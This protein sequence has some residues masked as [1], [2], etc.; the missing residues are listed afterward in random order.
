[1]GLHDIYSQLLHG[2]NEAGS[3]Q[4]GKIGKNYLLYEDLKKKYMIDFKITQEHVDLIKSILPDSYRPNPDRI[5]EQKRVCNELHEV[6]FQT[7]YE[8]EFSDIKRVL[9]ITNLDRGKQAFLIYTSM[10]GTEANKTK[11]NEIAKKMHDNRKAEL[12]ALKNPKNTEA[13]DAAREDLDDSMNEL[14]QFIKD[15]VV[16]EIRRAA[17]EAPNIEK[18]MSDST[19]PGK[20]FSNYRNI[21]THLVIMN[22]SEKFLALYKD[23]FSKEEYAS[24]CKSFGRVYGKGMDFLTVTGQM[25]NP[26]LAENFDMEEMKLLRSEELSSIEDSLE[27]WEEYALAEEDKEKEKNLSPEEK[28]K[29]KEA[30][31]TDKFKKEGEQSII[32]TM[33]NYGTFVDAEWRMDINN[34][35]GKESG[36]IV[37]QTLDGEEKLLSDEVIAELYE[38]GLP[39][40]AY[41][42]SADKPEGVICMPT[43]GH[44]L[45]VGKEAICNIE[46]TTIKSVTRPNFLAVALD[47][48]L[49]WMNE[50]WRLQSVLDYENKLALHQKDVELRKT[51]E[52]TKK[53]VNDPKQQ[54]LA[55]KF[56]GKIYEQV[57]KETLAQ[58]QKDLQDAAA[59]N[60]LTIEQYKEL[61][62]NQLEEQKLRNELL[63]KCITALGQAGKQ[64]ADLKAMGMP[65]SDARRIRLALE[66]S[67]TLV[68]DELMSEKKDFVKAAATMVVRNAIANEMDEVVHGKHDLDKLPKTLANICKDNKPVE[69]VEHTIKQL[70][71]NKLFAQYVNSMDETKRSQLFDNLPTEPE[72]RAKLEE[73]VGGFKKFTEAEEA[74]ENAI[75]KFDLNAGK[76][77]EPAQPEIKM[78]P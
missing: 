38:D 4:D 52:Y 15:N 35:F 7:A 30:R 78:I 49:G 45:A 17:A 73:F 1:M 8:I 27:E 9:G 37:I 18:L 24:L 3:Y 61:V 69:K 12:E 56:A 51:A 40:L 26:L 19:T 34:Y 50:D 72:Q 70:A 2:S 74:K 14:E 42:K 16:E 48:V 67:N 20:M 66:K 31:A 10:Y 13:I 22:E 11:L 60:K 29:L 53:M 28:Q 75:A 68:K 36:D 32:S 58:E 65:M 63:G 21:R 33:A 46:T 64:I 62:Q 6:I 47:G 59:R 5:A 76:H 43:V 57:R 39:F 55:D 54:Y 41:S 23:M 77:R 71:E 25:A 44:H